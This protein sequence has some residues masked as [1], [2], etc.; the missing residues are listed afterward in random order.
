ME[1]AAATYLRTLLQARKAG[2]PVD[3]ELR[4]A[5]VK[6]LANPTLSTTEK[7]AGFRSVLFFL[8]DCSRAGASTH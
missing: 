4:Q 6:Q 1:E 3:Q 8:K 5:A 2:V 7:P